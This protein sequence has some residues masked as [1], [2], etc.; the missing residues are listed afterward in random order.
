MPVLDSRFGGFY[1]P[2]LLDDLLCSGTET[3]LLECGIGMGTHQ[4]TDHTQ[5]AGVICSYDTPCEEDSLRLVPNELTADQLYLEEGEIERF[6][7]IDDEVHRGRVEV[8][9]SG[10]WE[11]VCYSDSWSNEDATVACA[12]LGFSPYGRY[13]VW[14]NADSYK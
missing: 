1:G 11:S 7:F 12:N 14:C 9:V 3:N 4:C 2:V 6:S 10:E 5:D 13:T 8:C